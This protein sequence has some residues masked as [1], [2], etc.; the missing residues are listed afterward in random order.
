MTRLRFVAACIPAGADR[1]GRMVTRTWSWSARC[2][3]RSEM[4][5]PSGGLQH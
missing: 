5:S 3:M 1:A 2:T 4:V